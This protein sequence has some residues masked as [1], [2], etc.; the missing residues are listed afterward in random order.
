MNRILGI[1][2]VGLASVA[3]GVALWGP[4]RSEAPATDAAP[5]VQ[6]TSADVRA[7]QTRVKALEE[8]VQLLSR[9]MMAFEQ[10][11]GTT[12][13]GSGPAPAG[14]EA[15]VAK[16]R[17]EV[18]AVMVGEA[19]NSESGK[20]S[21]KEILRTVQ[22]EQRTEQRQQWQQQIDQMRTQ[23]DAERSERLKTFITDA[24]LSYSQEQELTRQLQ[25]EDAKRQ[26][27]MSSGGNGQPRQDVRRQMREL[28]TQTDQE[29]QKVLSADQQAKY[30]EMRR[31]DSAPRGGGPRGG[32]G[33][34]SGW[35]ARGGA[36][37]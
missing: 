2:S 32:A 14:L 19:L 37:Q 24:R 26:A 12:P 13:G 16:L 34:G 21:L 28:R 22:D 6:D 4:G 20:Q 31:E 7:L 33:G 15:E 5:R 27:L 11:P 25:A 35:E 9:R 23:A 18:R 30:L 1:A 10:Q 3:L 36:T 8:T 17:E 29:M